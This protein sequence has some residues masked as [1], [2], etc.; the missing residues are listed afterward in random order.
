[1]EKPVK[2]I[3]NVLLSFLLGG[4]IL[5]W[6]Y[7]DFDFSTISGD[8]LGRLDWAW[9]ALS[10]LFGILAHVFRGIRWRL[11]LQPM[12]HSPRTGVLVDSV[13]LSYALSLVLPRMGEVA[14][15]ATLSKYENVPFSQGLGTIVT[16]RVIDA[17]IA[18]LAA[19]AAFLIDMPLFLDF[20]QKTGTRLPALMGLLRTPWFYV[21]AFSI[22][23]VGYLLWMAFGRIRLAERLQTTWK[24]FLDGLMSVRN[25]ASPGLF[26]F[27]T[28]LIWTCYFLHFFLTF[29][30]FEFTEDLGLVAGLS[31]FV[32]GTL[33]VVVPTPNGAGPWHFAV[34]TLMMLYGVGDQQASAFALVVHTIQTLLVAVLG[35]WALLHLA[36]VKP[37]R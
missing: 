13:Y 19:F 27:Y 37:R 34:I 11:M 5:Y 17:S 35:L 16:E 15:P 24:G 8:V 20:F 7:K 23:A 2:T 25:C 29:F 32:G 10:L 18:L 31:M 21:V 6:I 14:R 30:C 3:G 22:A 1:M 36:M 26:L 33:A 12:G 28:V 4:F 9:M